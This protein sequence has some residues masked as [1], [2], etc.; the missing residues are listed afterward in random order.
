MPDQREHRRTQTI[1]E[2]A[3]V[4]WDAIVFGYGA[5]VPFPL[6]VIAVWLGGPALG[7]L[8][9]RLVVIWGALVLVFLA[10]VRRGLSFRTPGG[11]RWMQIAMML[12]LFLAGL[13]ALALPTLVAMILL[14]L[15]Y[16]SL[17]V[18]DPIAA[19]H[20]ET[21]LYFARFRPWQMAVPVVSLLL[22]IGTTLGG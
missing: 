21:P 8:A 1:T 15:G 10:G 17:L 13:G 6:T 11:P 22:L 2:R 5:M 3:R 20:D 14:A 18:L 16:L 9:V 12:W 7:A 4:P 19:R